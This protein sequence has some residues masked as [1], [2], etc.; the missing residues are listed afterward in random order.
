MPLLRV[1]RL[2]KHFG[3]LRALDDVSLEVHSGEVVALVGQNGSGKST[4]VKIL[5]GVQSADSGTVELEEGN[6]SRDKPS[7]LRGSRCELHFIHQDLGL[8]PSLTTI[9]NLDL[10]R[11]YRGDGLA[12]TRR[13]REVAA[14]RRLITSFGTS[15]DVTLRVERLSSA[16]KT[17]VAIAR[18]LDGWSRDDNVLVLDEPTASLHGDEVDRL[19]EA[20]RRV[21]TRGAGVLFISHRLDEVRSIADRVVVLRDGQVVANVAVSD[22][23]QS[24][25]VELIVG[26]ALVEQ[27]D[28][29]SQP[30]QQIVLSARDVHGGS[31]RR[32]DI[33]LHVGEIVGVSGILGSGR[34]H[35]CGL[36]FG[37]VERNGGQVMVEGA[38]VEPNQAARSIR[39]GMGYVPANR[40]ADGMIPVMSV[41]ENLTLPRLRPLRG[42]LYRMKSRAE[43]DETRR[44]IAT[45]DVRPPDAERKLAVF[46]GGNQQKVVLGKWLRTEPRV[47]LL[48]EP[49]QGVDVGA[50]V[51]IYNLIGQAA[52]AGAGVLVASSDTKEL[53]HLCHRVLVFRDG[54]VVADVPGTQAT[55][56]RLTREGLG[57]SKPPSAPMS[58]K[59]GTEV[60]EPVQT[61][62]PPAID[63]AV[64][65]SRHVVDPPIVTE[66]TRYHRLR[67]LLGFRNI[68][69]LYI[70][71]VLFVVFALWVPGTFLSASTWKALLDNGA[72]TGIAAIGLVIPVAAGAFDLALGTELG[73]G[74]ILIAWL[75]GDH[76]VAPAI[77]LPAT[78]VAGGAVGCLS[79]LIITRAR[80]DSFIA[81]LGVSSVLLALISWISNDTEIL[82][83]SNSFQNIGN[84]EIFGIALPVYIML[85]VGLLVWYVL[86]RTPA[87]R[88]VYATGGNLDAAHLAGVPTSRVIVLSLVA[89]G[90]IAGLAGELVSA[91]IGAGDP[92]VGPPYLLP[93]FTAVFLGSTQFR[94]GRFN[95]W[96]AVVAVYVL[97]TGVKGLQLGGAPTWIPDLFNGVALLL[98]VGLAKREARRGGRP[99]LLTM[100]RLH[101]A[102]TA[103]DH[104]PGA[105]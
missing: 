41:R 72:V 50:K 66:P 39:A 54:A 52:A 48:D 30:R 75:I 92:T 8:V 20:V 88:R 12:P 94:E 1:S 96:G 89:C 57:I 83:L 84:K 61:P 62:A 5:A 29:D 93:V 36:L 38:A 77:A 17:I 15:F 49:T 10:G 63:A 28:I 14:A 33:D 65:S 91:Q 6:H 16:E 90:A 100:L 95:V 70:F 59:G 13:K 21:A 45:L 25:L 60:T 81:T 102:P 24:R 2:T 97:A 104:D 98:A 31:V 37:I 64:G 26:R 22:L 18:A 47:L 43:R 40:H 99:A 69:A 105:N 76:G 23:D 11:A 4:V 86:E 79:G 73:L 80:I 46:S 42:A 103:I 44:W 9:E 68:S 74:A 27:E 85:V 32:A 101:R 35:L 55:E 82:G 87:G 71:A 34:E 3:D 51:S 56:E 7:D 19:F 67:R 53:E 78:T 58:H